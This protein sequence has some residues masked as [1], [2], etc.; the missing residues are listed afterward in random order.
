M[1]NQKENLLENSGDPIS[2]SSLVLHEKEAFEVSDESLP[3][4]MKLKIMKNRKI[5]QCF[6]I[7]KIPRS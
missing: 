2:E 3:Q 6:W 1:K 5:I 4:K 7:P